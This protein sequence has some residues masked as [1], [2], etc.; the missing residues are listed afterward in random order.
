VQIKESDGGY[1]HWGQQIRVFHSALE[2]CYLLAGFLAQRQE[3][4]GKSK[5][6]GGLGISAARTI[7]STNSFVDPL[8][9]PHF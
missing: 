3:A 2:S 9:A 1:T 6:G 8:W 5:P 4:C 7:G